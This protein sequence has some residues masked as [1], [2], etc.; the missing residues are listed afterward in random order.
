MPKHLTTV[1]LQ[2][3]LS[4][5]AAVKAN[6]LPPGLYVARDTTFASVIGKLGTAPVGSPLS[7]NVLLGTTVLANLSF[8]DGTA[9]ASGNITAAVPGGSYLTFD[10]TAIGSGT[11]GADLSLALLGSLT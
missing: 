4:G 5:P 3:L 8:P 9:T 11:A 1:D 7:L 6:V 10:V 2:V